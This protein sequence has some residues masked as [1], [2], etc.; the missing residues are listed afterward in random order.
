MHDDS[1]NNNY[2]E[3]VGV[4]N[5]CKRFSRLFIYHAWDPRIRKRQVFKCFHISPV[6]VASFVGKL[7][8]R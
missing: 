3:S 6:G 4:F 8:S 2:L 1:S 7:K 5:G